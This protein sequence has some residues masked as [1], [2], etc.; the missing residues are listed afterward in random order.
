MDFFA[1]SLISGL[2][3]GS[4]YAL[5]A[6]GYSI[7]YGILRLINFAHGDLLMVATYGAWILIARGLSLPFAVIGSVLITV[8]FG[9]VIERAAYRPLRDAGE[10]ATLITSLAVSIF[11]QNLF[12]MVFTPKNRAFALPGFFSEKLVLGGAGSITIT[13][14][15]I[16]IFVVTGGLIAAVSL[17]I[18][19]TRLG[20]AMRACAE[21]STAAKLMGVNLN[22]VVVFAFVVGSALA[23][24]AGVLYSGQYVSFNP[25]MGFMIGIKAFAAAVIGGIGSFAGAAAGGVLLGVLE[26]LFACYLPEGAGVYQTAFVFLVLIVVLLFKPNGLFGA[27]EG[28][29]S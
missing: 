24:V 27:A 23:A 8:A 13:N 19:K 5:I 6:I 26:I 22:A 14:M 15:S 11:L 28:R 9:L 1:G 21:N 18:K 7:V 29:R 16:V 10:E 2:Q 3:L 4:I 20:I 17:I 12:L 25:S